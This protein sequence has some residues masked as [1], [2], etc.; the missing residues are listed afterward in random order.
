MK[1]PR[2][3]AVDLPRK[4][5]GNAVRARARATCTELR[6]GTIDGDSGKQKGNPEKEV[7]GRRSGNDIF[8][9]GGFAGGENA[10]CGN[11]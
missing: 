5:W 3:I 9:A 2:K 6:P 10:N 1:R 11:R 7:R 8:F 4:R